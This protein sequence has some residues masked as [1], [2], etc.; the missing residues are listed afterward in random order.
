MT[1]T[2]AAAWAPAS[3][4]DDV[5]A[6][7]P[8]RPGKSLFARLNSFKVKIL[9]FFFISNLLMMLA[10]TWKNTVA[11]VWF[12]ER[13][14]DARLYTAALAVPKI[15]PA[16]YQNGLLMQPISSAEASLAYRDLTLYAKRVGVRYLY[17]VVKKGHDFLWLSLSG[18]MG[19]APT[20]HPLVYKYHHPAAGAVRAWQTDTVQYS[21]YSGPYGDF[22]SVFVPMLGPGG[23]RYLIGADVPLQTF[24]EELKHIIVQSCLVAAAIF[25]ILAVSGHFL[26]S[27]LLSPVNRV[28]ARTASLPQNDFTLSPAART[29]LIGIEKRHSDEIGSLAGTIHHMTDRLHSYLKSLQETTAAKEHFESELRIAREIQMSFLK[30]IFPPYPDRR[31]FSL[32]A[33]IEPAEEIGGDL[34]AFNMVDED[35]LAF[36][37]GDVSDKGVPAS[38]VMAETMTLMKYTTRELGITPAEILCRVNNA[39]AE[40]NETGMFVT[41]FIGILDL[42]TGEL[43]FS[44]AG[45][46]PPL[47]LGA[48]GHCC[49]LTLPEG[50]VLGVTPGAEYSDASVWL[51][52]GDVIVAYTDGV[53]EAMDRD[54]TLYSEARLQGTVMNL[55]G[56]GVEDTVGEIMA[57]VRA[58]AAGASQSDDITV[59]AVKRG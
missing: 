23:Q 24:E 57:S 22:R 28:V 40:G 59:L 9:L 14:I 31:D 48:D 53:T 2:P 11:D 6:A 44:N 42:R 21:D 37:V 20:E 35:R 3:G 29:E 12:Y 19:K 43:K 54:R 5:A 56:R 52:P 45:H 38:L 41:L 17:T 36:Y 50:L 15:L 34:Y 58:H 30:H 46:N 1:D 55:A 10:Y 39:L 4:L 47:I 32:Y 27:R 51:D 8:R 13:A 25:I 49:Y 16:D 26:L 33:T 18:D 7:Q